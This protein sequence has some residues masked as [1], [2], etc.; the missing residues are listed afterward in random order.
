MYEVKP[1]LN[2]I[3]KERKLTQMQ[4]SELTNV[5]QSAISRFDQ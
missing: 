2:E 5:P 4:L 1:R 3:L